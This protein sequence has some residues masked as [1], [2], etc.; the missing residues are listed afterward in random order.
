MTKW[1]LGILL[2]VNVVFFALMQW[3]GALTTDVNLVAVQ[4]PLNMDK[5]RLVS[6][7]A[8]ASAAVFAMSAVASTNTAPFVPASILSPE[9]T[10]IPKP[11]KQCLEW[12]EFSGRA[13]AEVQTGLAT[14]KLGENLSQH[15]V[16]HA[17]GF[18]VF[19]PPLKN[20]AEVQRKIEQLK[21]LGI[22]DYFVV[23]EEGLWWNTIS[24]GVFKTEEA[25]QKFY[26]SLREKNVRSAK[27]GERM[28]KLK[29]TVFSLKGVDAA[30]IDKIKALQKGF[31]DSDLK[32][33]DCN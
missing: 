3:G 23:Q 21:K 33:V 26:E 2:T 13:L 16:E 6:E 27:V 9:L 5:I 22:N 8:P 15:S 28:S 29:F 25:A 20:H 11:N 17:G 19:I 4:V 32:S 31:P 14:L 18:W 12:G 1:V 30:T 7:V 24:L 10:S